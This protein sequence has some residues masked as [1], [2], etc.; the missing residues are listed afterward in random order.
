MLSFKGQVG[1]GL[2]EST[3][4]SYDAT[5]EKKPQSPSTEK[6]GC[7]ADFDSG[8][9]FTPSLGDFGR[10]N[11]PLLASTLPS[12]KYII[13]SIYAFLMFFHSR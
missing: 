10:D 6:S 12:I 11:D 4:H 7:N 5:V 3:S 13:F 8:L 9:I 1:S 2:K